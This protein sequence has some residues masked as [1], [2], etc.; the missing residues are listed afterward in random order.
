MCDL[1]I[2]QNNCIIEEDYFDFQ[3]LLDDI[4]TLTYLYSNPEE[5]ESSTKIWGMELFK[6]QSKD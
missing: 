4:Y 2:Y 5:N 6:Y 1:S 3:S